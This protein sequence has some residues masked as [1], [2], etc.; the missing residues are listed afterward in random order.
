MKRTDLIYRIILNLFLLFP[1]TPLSAQVYSGRNEVTA[2]A[3]FKYS[4][5]SSSEYFFNYLVLRELAREHLVEVHD[6]K[7]LF[8]VRIMIDVYRDGEG[9]PFVLLSFSEM[10]AS[11][12]T[13]CR[14]F[15]LSAFL[16]PSSCEVELT[17]ADKTDPAFSRTYSLMRSFNGAHATGIPPVPLSQFD[18][19]KDTLTVKISSLKFSRDGLDRLSE[20]INLISDYYASASLLDTVLLRGSAARTDSVPLMPCSMADIMEISRVTE[21]IIARGFDSTLLNGGPD[22]RSLRSKRQEAYRLSRTMAYN[23]I[24]QLDKAEVIVPAA[25]IDSMALYFVDGLIRYIRLSTTMSEIRGNIYSDYLEHYYSLR[26]FPDERTVVQRMA[27]RMFPEALADTLVPFISVRIYNAYLR[28]ARE[29]IGQH[30]YSDAFTLVRHARKFR[31]QVPGLKNVNGT[32]QL[33]SEAAAGVYAS[34]L[35]IAATS[36]EYDR[37][38]MAEIY[39]Q[40]ALE[41]KRS[42]EAYF[43]TD[44][45]YSSVFRKLFRQRLQHCD[46]LIGEERYRDAVHCYNDFE[47][48]FEPEMVAMVSGWI[49][50]KRDTALRLLFNAQDRRIRYYLGEDSYDSAFLEYESFLETFGYLDGDTSAIRTL[51]STMALVLPVKYK[52]MSQRAFSALES[53]DYDKSWNFFLI[54]DEVSTAAGIS[55]DSLY[56]ANQREAFRHHQLEEIASMTGYI[57]NDRFDSAYIYIDG[58]KEKLKMHDLSGDSSLALAI[59]GYLDRIRQRKCSNSMEEAEVLVLRAGRNAEGMRY[60]AAVQQYRS[61]NG[62]IHNYSECGISITGLEDSIRKYTP[63]AAYQ[64][65]TDTLNMHYVLGDYTAVLACLVDLSS[66]YNEGRLRRFG[67]DPVEVTRYIRDRNNPD[68]TREMV[69]ELMER[70]SYDEALDYLEIMKQ[71][72]AGPKEVTA[73]RARIDKT[74]KE[75]KP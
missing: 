52:V 61:A 32:Q 56:C 34:Y 75:A 8:T 64:L 74:L 38:D 21:L 50:A 10:E 25:G 17:H 13:S 28:R 73:L 6:V 53:R 15:D 22:P 60:V 26:S 49:T 4:S 31:D 29:L 59:R 48:R 54:A 19:A 3:G 69:M 39:I 14:G 2:A 63:A 70:H 57:W 35:G 45:L 46:R 24:D 47:S 23:F 68:L 36:I 1:L 65:E 11:G 9:K 5:D 66:A 27:E 20:R 40:K 30:A 44:T 37:F 72:G 16:I 18:P 67:L 43:E 55:H 33:L 58:V 62:I 71:Q 7:L 41:Y 42:N 51:N 12:H